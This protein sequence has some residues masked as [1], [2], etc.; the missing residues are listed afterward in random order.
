V[1]R[2]DGKPRSNNRLHD[3]CGIGTILIYFSRLSFQKLLRRLQAMRRKW[4]DTYI[5]FSDIPFISSRTVEK[6]LHR[7]R[8][9]RRTILKAAAGGAFLLLSG[10][11]FPPCRGGCRIPRPGRETLPLQHPHRRTTIR[12][13]PGRKGEYNP[14]AVPPLTASCAATT[15]SRLPRWTSGDRLPERRGQEPGRR[16]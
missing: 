9:D 2:T 3:C 15:P 16:K 14:E 11:T 13:L 1:V 5:P 8:F 7:T 6:P 12:R 4:Y 10:E